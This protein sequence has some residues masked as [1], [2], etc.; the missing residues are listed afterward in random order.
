MSENNR[1]EKVRKYNAAIT[2]DV[3]LPGVSEKIGEEFTVTIRK[4]TGMHVKLFEEMPDEVAQMGDGKPETALKTF[5]WIKKLVA[6][7][8]ISPKISEKPIGEHSPEEL[9]IDALEGDLYLI[10]TEVMALSG[11]IAAEEAEKVA[12]EVAAALPFRAQD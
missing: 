9:S 5:P 1:L 10:V 7:T 2:R 3:V 8:V 11:L 6:A 4:L 12:E